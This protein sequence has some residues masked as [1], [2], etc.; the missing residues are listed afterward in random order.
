MITIYCRVFKD[1]V[2]DNVVPRKRVVK[3]SSGVYTITVPKSVVE[4]HN[5]QE[6]EFDLQ[7]TENKII[8]TKVKNKNRPRS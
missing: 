5:W 3:Q 7:V 8:L 6:A 4:S 2:G 1:Y